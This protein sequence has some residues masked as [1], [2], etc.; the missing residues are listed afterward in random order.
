MNSFFVKKHACY[1]TL[2]TRNF[3]LYLVNKLLIISF[4]MLLFQVHGQEPDTIPLSKTEISDSAYLRLIEARRQEM[5]KYDTTAIRQRIV[6]SILQTMD[7]T[8]TR[9]KLEALR[10][11]NEALQK[12]L[13]EYMSKLD[14]LRQLNEQLYL[15]QKG[16][17]VKLS[18]P[19]DTIEI[20]V[21][22]PNLDYVLGGQKAVLIWNGQ[23]LKKANQIQDT[24]STYFEESRKG[25]VILRL[26]SKKGILRY[27]GMWREEGF[28]DEVIEFD[29]QGMVANIY[30]RETE[31]WVEKKR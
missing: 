9:T 5:A 11:E 6:D 22:N 30:T 29:I 16:V 28:I 25:A 8:M 13:G 21:K 17:N 31:R 15:E 12:V 24:L 27:M 18:G 3:Y 4:L 14:S 7:S 2:L 19:L 1:C 20:R 23:K 10:I 26:C